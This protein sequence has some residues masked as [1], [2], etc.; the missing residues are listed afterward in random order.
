M[1]TDW[2]T[3]FESSGPMTIVTK[4]TIAPKA[5]PIVSI[6][7][8]VS[9]EKYEKLI[10]E[11]NYLNRRWQKALSLEQQ[12]SFENLSQ[13]MEELICRELRKICHR[14]DEIWCELEAKAPELLKPLVFLEDVN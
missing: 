11:L 7:S 4:E 1:T 12:G 8:I 10:D 6:V 3:V 9:P 14:A 13:G 2:L 5:E